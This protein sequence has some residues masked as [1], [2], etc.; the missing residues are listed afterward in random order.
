MPLTNDKEKGTPER[1]SYS[2][3]TIYRSEIVVCTT[4]FDFKN[5]IFLLRVSS[6]VSCVPQ[7]K[8]GLTL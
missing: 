5:N 4:S 8:Q 6:S 1:R 2:A 7:N 3:L